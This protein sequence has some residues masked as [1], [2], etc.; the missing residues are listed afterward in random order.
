MN[1]A[2][3]VIALTPSDALV[4]ILRDAQATAADQLFA[5]AREV[6]QP[7]SEIF[8]C[9][10]AQYD[11]AAM[12]DNVI[13]YETTREHAIRQCDGE[14]IKH[15]LIQGLASLQAQEITNRAKQ[16]PENGHAH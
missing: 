16:A 8:D 4:E 11:E 7:D 9:V 3:F 6:D 12:A 1:R 5:I 10:T 2:I 14:L 13:K 15:L